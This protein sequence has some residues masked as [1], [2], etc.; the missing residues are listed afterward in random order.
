MDWRDRETVLAAVKKNGRL[1]TQASKK[2]RADREVV[3]TAIKGYGHV[4]TYVAKELRADREVVLAAVK[5][6]GYLLHYASPKIKTEVINTLH[7]NNPLICID[8]RTGRTIPFGEEFE[9]KVLHGSFIDEEDEVLLFYGINRFGYQNREVIQTD[10]P[11]LI[12]VNT[13]FTR[14]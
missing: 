8:E 6:A 4:F 10:V 5:E 1:L 9:G 7:P 2:L 14:V 3:L 11:R 12:I 13:N